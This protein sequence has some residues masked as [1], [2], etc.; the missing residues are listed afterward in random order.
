MA[1]LI[2]R[3]AAILVAFFVG[4]APAA[5]TALLNVGVTAAVTASVTSTFQLRPGPAGG[6]PTNMTLQGNFTYGSG[7]TSADAFV[8]TSIDGGSTWV[9]VAEFHFTTSSQRFVYNLSSGT[10]VTAEYMPTDGSLQA[11]TSKDGVFG[12]QW[13]VKYTT[14]G[15]YV[16]TTLR[17]DG[18]ANG[19]TTFTPGD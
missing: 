17:I 16:G 1:T 12:N 14:V 18:F 8:Q 10:P 4:C 6:L 5:A 19:L 2:M 7:G 11:N 13:R 3:L 15:T 9:D